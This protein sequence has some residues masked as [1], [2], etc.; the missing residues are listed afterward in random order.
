MKT[1]A[2][3]KYVYLAA[4]F[5]NQPELAFTENVAKVLRA[6]FSERILL[7]VPHQDTGIILT[8]QSSDED[9]TLVFEKNVAELRRAQILILLLD[10]EDSGTCWE[11]G[12]GYAN[13]LSMIGLWTDVRKG[14]NLMLYKSAN[15]VSSIETLIG[16]LEK[17]L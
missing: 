5:F 13:N 14:P 4:P 15:I 11:M 17:L 12:Y 8:P 2:E 7:Y 10:N 3:L 16:E 1:L 6:N 9:R